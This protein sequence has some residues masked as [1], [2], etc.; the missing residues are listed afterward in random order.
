MANHE[1]AHDAL[2][3]RIAEQ[4]NR[5]TRQERLIAHLTEKGLPTGQAQELL[6]LMRVAAAVLRASLAHYPEA[7]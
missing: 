2:L 6:A 4:E 5:V 1:T 3:R 7:N